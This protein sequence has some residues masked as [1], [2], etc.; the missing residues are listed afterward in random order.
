MSPFSFL[1]QFVTYMAC[2][3]NTVL[4]VPAILWLLG[5]GRI[6]CWTGGVLIIII[7]II[8]I[9]LILLLLLIIIITRPWPAFARPGLGWII[10]W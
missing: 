3:F 2:G 6:G 7:I 8:L 5:A 4:L 9:I 10:G 1:F